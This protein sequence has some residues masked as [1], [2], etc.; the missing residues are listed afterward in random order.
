MLLRSLKQAVYQPDNK[1]H[2]GLNYTTYSHFTSPIRRYPDLLVHRAIRSVIVNKKKEETSNF[3]S[4]ENKKNYAEKLY[5]YELEKIIAFGEQFSM[6]ERRADDATREVQQW[7]KCEYLSD[8]IGMK[9]SGTVSGVANFGL[10]IELKDIQIDGLLHVTSLP[11]DYYA[12]DA[13]RQRLTGER[14]GVH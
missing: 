12:F 13:S 11:R 6:T 9:Y 2:F 8:C 14:S 1:G 4:S 10:F 3:T 5:P 7:L